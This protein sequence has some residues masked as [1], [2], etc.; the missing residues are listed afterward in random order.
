VIP[1]QSAARQSRRASI[2]NELLRRSEALCSRDDQ[3][4]LGLALRGFLPTLER[5]FV[6]D[7]L[8]EQG[9]DIFW[10]LT[11]PTEI[12][13][14]EVLR[15]QASNEEHVFPPQMMNI[16]TFRQTRHSRDV[17]E[18]LEIALELIRA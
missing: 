10:V 17:R 3:S 8:P 13:K 2:R 14:I 18:K 1:R 5:A 12:V 7:C 16:A 9:E 15:N 4:G 11:G 6:L